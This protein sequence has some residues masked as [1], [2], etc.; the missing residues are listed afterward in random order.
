MKPLNDT[1]LRLA[2]SLN[3]RLEGAHSKFNGP[4]SFLYWL[5]LALGVL[6]VSAT[7]CFAQTNAYTFITIAGSTNAGSADGLG[8]SALFNNPKGTAVDKNY[9]VY[10][11]DTGN[12]I[13]R[14]IV[15]VQTNWLV[16]TI[17]GFAGAIYT[18]DD[19]ST[20]GVG[21]QNPQN[22]DYFSSSNNYTAGQITNVYAN[23]FGGAFSNVLFSLSNVNSNPASG[24]MQVNL[25]WTPGSQ[26]VIHH[27]NYSDN[28]NVSSLTYTSVVMD[29]RWDSSSATGTGNVGYATFGP[30][31]LGVRPHAIYN[32]QDWFYSTN[33]PASMTNWVH[34][35]AP[36]SAFDSN[37]VNWGELLIGAD[38]STIGSVLNGPATFYVDNIRFLGPLGN[39][40]NAGSADGTGR[41]ARFNSPKGIT[42]DSTGNVY[43][44][45]TSNS[46]IRKLTP[47]GSNW[48]VSTIAGV[49]GTN[50]S[51]DGTGVNALFN[52]PDGIAVD[53]NGN[54]FV[55]DTAN[56]TIRKITPIGSN[57][58]VN[59]IAGFP[60][61][62]GTND[63]INSLARFANPQGIAVDIADNIYVAD[64][65]NNTIRKIAPVG[66]NWIVTT[67]AGRAGFTG[68]ADGTNLNAR[69]F[70]PGGITVDSAGNL[71]ATDSGNETIRK[72]IQSGTNWV[73]STIGGV[74]GESGYSDGKG[75]NALFSIPHGICV[76][77][78]GDLFVDGNAVQGGAIAL[79]VVGGSGQP[80]EIQV[81]L[82][83]S[84]AVMAG[85]AW[86]VSNTPPNPFY[87]PKY[88]NN[89]WQPVSGSSAFLEFTNL[90]GWNVPASSSPLSVTNDT[91][92]LITGLSYTV[93]PPV[94]DV[95]LTTN[96]GI[97]G[98]LGITGTIS[99]SY[100]IDYTTNLKSGSWQTLIPSIQLGSGLNQIASWPTLMATNSN[101]PAKFY[102]AVWTGN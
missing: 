70:A 33:I 51:S 93:V 62:T 41:H 16:S 72:L 35:I 12:N 29:V 101:A 26:F 73:V 32:V 37:Q 85:A 24:S 50:G 25:Y 55:A 27:A 20:N 76:N 28:P 34:I 86:A 98:T 38:S 69:F 63:G 30:L 14:E 83:P 53:T 80:P 2:R 100:R 94:L 92:Y 22:H 42:V 102:R 48:V 61:I 47:I 57:W 91:F 19:F 52:H 8:R 75:T 10:V 1:T 59:T 64:T 88:D 4:R 56:S 15:T 66:T 49:A 17:A 7:P 81:A 82:A 58:V 68:S 46:T 31:R 11:A 9:N 36:L 74:A 87:G 90:P 43:V 96:S 54:L 18:A 65:T 39:N 71:Y 23:W 67:I 44:A 60:G 99:T 40:G 45:D 5:A 77:S 6:V 13:I 89:D 97:T 84:T 78:L 3:G 79:E 95:S 21:P